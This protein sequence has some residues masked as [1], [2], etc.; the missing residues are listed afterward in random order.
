VNKK[1]F[2]YDN[3]ALEKR[4]NYLLNNNNFYFILTILSL[5]F[6]YYINLTIGYYLI[7]FIVSF[8]FNYKNKNANLILII[9]TI[10]FIYLYY[11]I[12]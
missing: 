8:W 5:L 12:F 4:M 6:S 3:E 11:F 10:F 9:I 2:N 1:F 7:G